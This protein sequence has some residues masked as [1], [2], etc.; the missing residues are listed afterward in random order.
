VKDLLLAVKRRGREVA[1]QYPSC[2]EVKNAWS[3]IS[4]PSH[5]FIVQEQ[6]NV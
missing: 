3:Y 1:H 2:A 4:V 5:A 6:L